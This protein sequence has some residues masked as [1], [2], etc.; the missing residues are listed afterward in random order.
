[1]VNDNVLDFNN[2]LKAL[3]EVSDSFTVD[4]WIP[5]IQSNLTFKQLNAK[6]QKQLLGAAMDTSV[7]N[8]SFIKTFYSILKDNL[9]TENVNIDNLTLVDKTCIG[10][11]L[12]SKISNEITV[13]FGEKNKISNKF[14]IKPILDSLKEY[15]TPKPALLEENNGSFLLKTEILYPTIKV[16]FDYDSQFKGNKKPEEVKTTEDIQKLVSESFIGEISKYINKVWINESEVELNNLP[17]EQRIKL[18]E[19]LPSSLLQ[20]I[21]DKISEWKNNLDEILT[22]KYEDYTQTVNVDSIMFLN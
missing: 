5:S 9:I 12:K 6:Q 1:M 8:T 19:K 10:L 22:V 13:F 16:E 21:I 11:S 18:I 4:S 20:K 2:A 7:Y 3:G 15:I 17:F 14:E